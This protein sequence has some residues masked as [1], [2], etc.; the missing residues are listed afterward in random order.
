MRSRGASERMGLGETNLALLPTV[1]GPEQERGITI[2]V[3]YRYF[4][5]P[6]RKFIIAGHPGPHQCTRNMVTGLNRRPTAIDCWMPER[7]D[8]QSPATRSPLRFSGS[9]I[10]WWPSTKMDLV[11]WRGPVQRD[12]RGVQGFAKLDIGDLAFIRCRAL[13]GSDNRQSHAREHP[14]TRAHRCCR[15]LETV[16][17]VGPATSSTPVFRSSS[18][19]RPHTDEHRLPQ[20]QAR[21][22]AECSNQ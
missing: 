14:G 6:K 20:L 15:H 4:P 1:S 16:H 22:Q 9:P 18:F 5:T 2:D 21:S 11:D 10:S 3:A 13:R 19:L 17:I 8:Q 12:R 7:C